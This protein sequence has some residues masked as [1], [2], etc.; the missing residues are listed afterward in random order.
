M[1][2]SVSNE[3]LERPGPRDGK[4]DDEDDKA[5]CR[6][7]RGSFRNELGISPRRL[8][9]DVPPLQI[10]D[11]P[12]EQRALALVDGSQLVLVDRGIPQEL[13][14]LQELSLVQG[15]RAGSQR[16]RASTTLAASS[17]SSV[18]SSYRG[19]SSCSIS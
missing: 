1:R 9:E 5:E 15:D 18:R 13:I 19:I 6:K 10:V 16:D 17:V 12:R 4:D 7:R 11:Q 3:R 8:V 2:D 14:Q